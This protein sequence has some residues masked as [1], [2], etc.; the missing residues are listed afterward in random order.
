MALNNNCIK[1]R[2]SKKTY[3]DNNNERNPFSE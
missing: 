3:N 2:K 1:H